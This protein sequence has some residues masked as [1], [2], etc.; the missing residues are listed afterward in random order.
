MFERDFSMG[1]ETPAVWTSVLA[2]PDVNPDFGWGDPGRRGGCRAS[3]RVTV[4]VAGRVG[5]LRRDSECGQLERAWT[6]DGVPLLLT[7]YEQ[8][9][10]REAFL[11][12]AATFRRDE[13]RPVASPSGN[14]STAISS[15]KIP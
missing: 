9:F 11:A 15:R 14:P 3:K 5:S 13:P 1:W 12:L 4:T 10:T 6:L 2:A 8:D 7:G